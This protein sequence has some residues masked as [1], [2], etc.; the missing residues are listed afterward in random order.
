MKV[1][2]L[3]LPRLEASALDPLHIATDDALARA[4]GVRVAFTGRAGGVSEQPYAHLNLGSHVGD[5]PEAVAGNRAALMR[6]LGAGECELVVPNQVHGDNLVVVDAADARALEAARQEASAGADGVVVTAPNVAALLC[7][8]DCV[9]VIIV[10]LTGSFAVVHAGWRGVIASIVPKAARLLA[11]R[12]SCGAHAPFAS[13]KEALSAY[14]VYVGPHIHA[15][16]FE[17]GADVHAR[18]AGK[19]GESCTPDARHVDLACAL[20]TDLGRAG[21]C[22]CRIADVGI[23]TACNAQGFFSYRA[24]G[25]VCGRHGAIAFR[26]E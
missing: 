26:K 20:R 3:P 4:T 6:A 9:P 18:F 25:G 5:D 22:A 21:I 19:F 11:H 17:T 8:A 12:E 2:Q 15:E 7:F 1:S 13:E 10:S 16:C 14:N 23:C 24:S